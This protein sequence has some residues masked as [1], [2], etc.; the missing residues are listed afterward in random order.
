MALEMGKYENVMRKFIFTF[1]VLLALGLTQSCIPDDNQY[2]K[3]SYSTG[4]EV[5]DPAEPDEDN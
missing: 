4:D 5:D 2:Q 1:L 3:A